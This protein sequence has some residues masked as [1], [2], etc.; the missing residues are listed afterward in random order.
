MFKNLV[1]KY[2]I[3]PKDAM[4]ETAQ[5]ENT[6]LM[7]RL[8][9]Q[10]L[11]AAAVHI[12]EM[13]ASGSEL[14]QISRYKVSVLDKIYG[15]LCSCYS[16]PPRRFDFEYVDKDGHYHIERD[17]TPQTFFETYIGSALSEPFR[18]SMLR[19]MT[20]LITAPILFLCS[21]ML[22]AEKRSAI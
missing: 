15:Y 2:G 18:S 9:N 3:V 11:K 22:W 19:L 1:A 5:S 13:A 21:E 6:M 16:E 17:Y 20:N 12:R 10:A 14:E 4:P 8:L 7:N